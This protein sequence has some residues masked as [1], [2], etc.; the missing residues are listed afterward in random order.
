MHLLII[1]TQI[2][3]SLQGLVYIFT[4][5]ET[6]YQSSKD[7]TFT[8]LV[9]VFITVC[10]EP[11]EIVEQTVKAAKNMDYPN[12]NVYILNDG[13]VA[14]KPNWK[15]IEELALKYNVHCITR[16]TP[17]GNKSGNVNNA[18]RMTNSP[19]IAEFDA[20]HIP[21]KNFLKKTMGYFSHPNVGF[22]QTPQYYKNHAKNEI[23][24][25][26]W[27]QQALFFGAICKGKNRLNSNFLCGTNMIIRRSAIEGVG[28][29]YEENIAEDFLTSLFIHAKGWRS[30]YVPEVLA[31][32]LAPEDFLSYYKQ[33]FRWARGSLEVIFKFNP[34][35][36]K[37]LSLTQKIQYLYSAGY[38]LSGL[39]V[40]LNIMIPLLYFFT[41][42]I[43]LNIS[44]MGITLAFLPYIFLN[45]L[46]LQI[47]SNFT[48]TFK[49][50]TFSISSF[51]LQITAILAVI[52]NKKS[53]FNV[54][55]KQQLTGNYLHLNT[56]HLIYVGL[57]IFGAFIAYQRE[58]LSAALL[59]NIAWSSI[60]IVIFYQFIKA[61]LPQVE[62]RSLKSA[63]SY[64]SNYVFTK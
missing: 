28:G 48:Y 11:V 58:G 4:I 47:S 8:P 60:Y 27:D 31:E 18:L 6:E 12:F 54:T 62:K 30:V 57:V 37:G 20:D 2:Y 3:F 53:P 32:G 36:M 61:S 43:P 55:S 38:Y 40:L 46:I 34:L 16:K 42:L 35:F 33:Q 50:L 39:I 52:F 45:I 23:T 64:K 44:S 14:N 63:Q 26:A 7:D 41:G 24:E 21:S 22:I 5:W 17:G 25:A 29:M 49:A 56:A 9:D 13:F 59:N 10:G 1:I 15:E 51:Y 19:F